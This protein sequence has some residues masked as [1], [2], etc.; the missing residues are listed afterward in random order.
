[1]QPILNR[2]LVYTELASVCVCFCIPA[3]SSSIPQ[4]IGDEWCEDENNNYECGYD[5]GDCCGQDVR[6]TYCSECECLGGNI[7]FNPNI[8]SEAAPGPYCSCSVESTLGCKF[9]YLLS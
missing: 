5:G 9:F 7:T 1:M 3:C 4:F 2:F 8:T 6:T